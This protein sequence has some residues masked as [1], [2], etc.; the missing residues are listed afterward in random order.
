[1]S[2]YR[3]TCPTESPLFKQY[4]QSMETKL[5]LTAYFTIYLLLAG[6]SLTCCLICCTLPQM[7]T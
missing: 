2:T 6:L 7:L 1:M 5:Y 3:L 4:Y